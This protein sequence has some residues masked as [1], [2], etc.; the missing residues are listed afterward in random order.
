MQR[1]VISAFLIILILGGCVTTVQPERRLNIYRS[2]ILEW[3]LKIKQEGWSESLLD[4]VIRESL[5]LTNYKSD[6]LDQ[7]GNETDQWKMPTEFINDNF[8]GDCED[9]ATFLYWNL[10]KRL[11][12]P[13]QVRIR[14]VATLFPVS[15]HAVLRVELPDKKWKNYETIPMA[16]LAIIDSFF[17]K[18][19]FEFDE[20]NIYLAN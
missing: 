14:A 4:T 18:P 17:Y 7:N 3:Q 5:K 16:G 9:I 15:E 8:Q 6:D 11:H 10:K 13:H 2:T 12:Y 1:L 20:E 19:L